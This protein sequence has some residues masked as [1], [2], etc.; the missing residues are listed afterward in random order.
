MCEMY[1]CG[2][3]FVNV[4]AMCIGLQ[5]GTIISPSPLFSYTFR[6]EHM[7]L[8]KDILERVR[9]PMENAL[10]KSGMKTTSSFIM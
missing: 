6:E 10:A 5:D 8:C 7:E 3:V 2:Y 9:I 4:L 1:V